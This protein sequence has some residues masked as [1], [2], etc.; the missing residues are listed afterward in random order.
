AFAASFAYAAA[1]ASPAIE[2]FTANGELFMNLPSVAAVLAAVA[3]R[4]FAAGCLAVAATLI[5]PTALPGTAAAL[6]AAWLI[7]L[8]GPRR[9]PWSAARMVFGGIVGVAPFIAHGL[10]SGPDDFW[11]AVVGFRAEEHSAFSAGLRFFDELRQTAPHVL[12]A[13]LPLWLLVAVWLRRGHWRFTDGAVLV[14]FLGGT[15]V[16]AALGGYWYWHYFV[17]V[18][19]P[20][21]LI[22][23][24]ALARDALPAARRALGTARLAIRDRTPIPAIAPR[25]APLIG[26]ALARRPRFG[27]RWALAALVASFVSL[28]ANAS[29]VGATPDETSWRLYRRQGYLASREVARYLRDRT[30][31][32]DTV[33][34][35][36]AGADVYFMSHRRSAARH[37]YWTEINRVP[38]ALDAVVRTLDDPRRCPKYVVRLQA[39][40]E[41]PGRAGPFWERVE[42]RFFTEAV[43]R[44]VVIYRRSDG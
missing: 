5:K 26:A 24:D 4:P 41:Q 32:D 16:G 29:F 40:L 15:L 25:L 10:L 39:E 17:G 14:A 3:G 37:L 23:G 33:Y 2:G 34:A 19:P 36:F 31:P 20:A 38:G 43:I 28:G 12:W 13:L 27:T 35:A 11:Y 42:R 8:G 44:G 22:A 6:A 7:G 18:L 21:A 30:S 1:S 9:S